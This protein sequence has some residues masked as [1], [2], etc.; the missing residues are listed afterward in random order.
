MKKCPACKL[1]NPT[2]A[3]RCDCG[4]D[5]PSG[6]IK[7]SYIQGDCQNAIT[8]EI[9]AEKRAEARAWLV[10]AV[11]I[12]VVSLLLKIVHVL[13]LVQILCGIA[14]VLVCCRYIRCKGY[15]WTDGLIGIFS[16]I[17]LII[18]IRKPYKVVKKT[19]TPI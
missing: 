16:L 5:F 14:F 13:A 11:F 9:L 1:I 18:L 4:Y 12:F 10:L 2:E 6:Q 7:D 17:G 15:Q 8:P 19:E 3:L